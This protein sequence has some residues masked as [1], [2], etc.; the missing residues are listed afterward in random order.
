MRRMKFSG[1]LRYKQ[2]TQFRP[3][4][5]NVVL[6]NTNKRTCDQMDFAVTVDHRAKIKEIEKIDIY[7]DLARDQKVVKHKVEGDTNCVWSSLNSS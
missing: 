2:I 1:I 5:S 6:I 7:L 3:E 4:I